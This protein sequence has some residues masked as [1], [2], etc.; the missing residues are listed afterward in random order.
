MKLNSN[1]LTVKEA[2]ELLNTKVSFIRSALFK[3]EI[4]FYRI[5]K[6]LIRFD[7]NELLNWIKKEA[8]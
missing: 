3:K 5:G 8:K 7:R 6:K 2:A 4:P 1:L